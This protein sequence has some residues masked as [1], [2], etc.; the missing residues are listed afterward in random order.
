MT[1]S[2]APIVAVQAMQGFEAQG[3][4]WIAQGHR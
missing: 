1:R 4:R 3:S 2:R